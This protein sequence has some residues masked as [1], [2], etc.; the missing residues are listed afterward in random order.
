MAEF[1]A[2]DVKRLRELTAAGFMECKRALEEAD[3]DFDRAVEILKVKGAK[4]VDKRAARVAANGLVA[5]SGGA[6]IELNCETDFVAKSPEVQQLAADLAAAAEASG[7]D[8]PAALG[9]VA[10]P[11]GRTV[12]EA[13]E[14][15]SAT[16]GEKIVLGRVAALATPVAT[17][18]HRKDRAL[19]PQVGVLVSYAGEEEAARAAAMQVAAMRARFVTRDEVPDAEVADVRRIAEEK[20]RAEGKPEQALTKIS[21]GTVNSF[22][23]D[24]VL[25]EQA[26]VT[27]PK[28][29]VKAQLDAAGTSVTRFVRFEV[30]G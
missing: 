12:A 14:A 21:D 3:G 30:G 5:A 26:S 16:M 2:A 11:D 29:T 24:T 4:D 27:D 1:T 17:Y 25:L 6:I 28:T 18:L 23:K 7:A 22:F 8:D 9:A 15:V 19:P 10:L 20:A 13:V